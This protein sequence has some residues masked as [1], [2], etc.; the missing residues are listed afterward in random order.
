M[1]IM[2]KLNLNAATIMKIAGLALVA[3]IVLIFLLRLISSSFG[4]SLR[5]NLSTGTDSVGMAY[6]TSMEKAMSAGGTG[7]MPE[8]SARNIASAPAPNSGT[9]SGDT[10]EDFEVT[11]YNGTIETRNLKK[12]CGAISGLKA[13]DYVIFES[14]YEYDHGCNYVFKVRRENTDEIF[15]VVKGLDPRDLTESIRTIKRQIDDYTSE[16][17]IL[18]KKKESIENTLNDAITAYDEISRVA[19]QARDSE[20]LAK[21]IDSKIR[22]IESLTQQRINVETQLDRLARAKADELDRIDYTYF[23]LN[24]YENKFIDGENLRDSW[25]AAIKKFVTDINGIFQDASLGLVAAIFF[26]LQYA[27][28]LLLILI[29]AKYG[30]R[31]ARYIWRK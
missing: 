24:I 9:V 16:T 10:A 26:V 5:Q 31:L 23:R 17:E 19:T 22:I 3:V 2:K 15:G 20:S 1:E 12:T 13:K 6:D 7:A 21:I 30:W 18:M 14:A 11:E 8:L 27:L 28:Y 4:T 29:A 25:K